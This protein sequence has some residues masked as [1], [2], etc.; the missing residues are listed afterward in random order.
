[1]TKTQDSN[2]GLLRS[3][4]IYGLSNI[5]QRAI[6]F[7][8]LPILTH[9]LSAADFGIVAVF[10]AIVRV[11]TPLVGVNGPYV[12][13]RQYFASEHSD[14]RK[15]VAGSLFIL[16]SGVVLTVGIA[17]SLGDY[18]TSFGLPVHWTLLAVVTAGGQVLMLVPLTIW[19]V[20]HN[21]RRYAV[22]QIVRSLGYAGLALLLVVALGHRWAGILGS[23]VISDVL[24]VLAVCL[25]ALKGWV[26]FKFDLRLIQHALR[27]GGGL[28]PHTLGAIA[29]T[30]VDR[31]FCQSLL[32]GFGNRSLLGG[33]PNWDGGV[34]S[35]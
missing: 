14:F 6:P 15:Y 11:C 7:L 29:I 9:H 4:S 22:V 31:F 17:W 30:S 5:L 3:T 18:S 34:L 21:A 32:R 25:P 27:Y 24:L 16:A 35:S 33:L 2:P 20:E 8:L 13:R 19:Q 26:T 23:M 28:V 10:T 12:I 1:M